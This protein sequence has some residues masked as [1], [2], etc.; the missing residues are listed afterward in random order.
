[1]TVVILLLFLNVVNILLPYLVVISKLLREDFSM[2]HNTGFDTEIGIFYHS[3][4]TE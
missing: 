2:W 4:F 1:M 3:Y